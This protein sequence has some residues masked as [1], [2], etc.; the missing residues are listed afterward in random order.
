MTHRFHHSPTP[1]RYVR[2]KTTNT[3]NSTL[4]RSQVAQRKSSSVDSL[5]NR[6]TDRHTDRQTVCSGRMSECSA[7]RII[8]L[9]IR[10]TSPS[11]YHNHLA[12]VL[13]LALDLALDLDLD[14]P[15]KAGSQV[16]HSV[17]SHFP[18]PT[19]VILQGL[20]RHCPRL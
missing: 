1:R 12:L 3:A 19:C 18:H 11:P 4:I 17:A 13:D 7:D 15:S 2:T 10:D 8:I 14:Q 5:N 6:Q 9:H 20:Q 16:C